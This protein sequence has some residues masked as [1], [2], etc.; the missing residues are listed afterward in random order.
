[1][2]TVTFLV[3]DMHCSS[4]AM[5]LQSLED[6]L[7]GVLQVDASYV[8]QKMVVTFDESRVSEVQ[9]IAAVSELGY[10]AHTA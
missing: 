8:K 7:P 6:D 1:M 10:S 9:I 2:K 4:C 5:R 3:A